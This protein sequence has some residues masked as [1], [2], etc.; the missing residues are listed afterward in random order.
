MS[1]QPQQLVVDMGGCCC[2]QQGRLLSLLA[3]VVAFVVGGGIVLAGRKGD[4][5]SRE[6][7][8]LRMLL[9]VG[10]VVFIF[11]SE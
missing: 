2:C 10:K 11:G 5:V 6:R 7:V 8:R 9:S 3:G 4:C 1:P